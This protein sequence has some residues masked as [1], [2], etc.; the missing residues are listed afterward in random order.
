M[1]SVGCPR[2]EESFRVPDAPLP[3]DIRLRCPW[4]TETFKLAELSQRLLPMVELID[5]FDQTIDLASLFSPV[6]NFHNHALPSSPESSP[7][8]SPAFAPAKT[9]QVDQTVEIDGES[10]LEISDV[11]GAGIDLNTP[12]DDVLRANDTASD[13]DTDV[14]SYEASE[15]TFDSD[16][17]DPSND[18]SRY[19]ESEGADPYQTIVEHGDRVQVTGPVA[20]RPLSPSTTHDFNQ[21]ALKAKPRQ[22]KKKSSPVMQ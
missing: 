3:P 18:S 17:F 15:P 9:P 12:M 8:F 7:E 19:D 5:E 14:D 2:C 16:Q 20:P 13:V 21:G 6:S 10:D 4:C 22:Q 11:V 1:S